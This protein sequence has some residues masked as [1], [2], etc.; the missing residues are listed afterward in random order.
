M[1]EKLQVPDGWCKG[2]R[3]NGYT[4]I[5]LIMVDVE[6]V[7]RDEITRKFAYRGDLAPSVPTQ[8]TS[9]CKCVPL[10]LPSR[11]QQDCR[12]DGVEPQ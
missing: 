11:M 5:L 6:T 8:D 1:R 4:L 10:I 3:A 9:N 7:V 2:L 12:E